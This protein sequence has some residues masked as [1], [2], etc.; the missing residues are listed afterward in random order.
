MRVQ[1]VKFPPLPPDAHVISPSRADAQQNAA[2][3]TDSRTLTPTR[4]ALRF[5]P[6]YFFCFVQGTPP[7][8][9]NLFLCAPEFGQIFRPQDAHVSRGV[10]PEHGMWMTLECRAEDVG[11]MTPPFSAA[12]TPQGFGNELALQLDKPPTEIAILCNNGI[13]VIRRR[14]LVDIFATAVQYSVRDEGLESEVKRFIRYYGREETTATALSVACAQGLDIPPD[15]RAAAIAGP[16]IVECARRVFIE[17]GGKPVLDENFAVDNAGPTVDDVRLSPRHQAI[18]LYIARLVRSIWQASVILEGVSPSGGLSVTPAVGLQKLRDIQRDMSA[19]K[20]FL[21]ANK[22][23]IEGLA[24]PD[25]LTRVT[26]KQD[27]LCLEAEHRALHS[28][29]VLIANIIEG[30]AFV[31]VLFDEGVEE[32]ILSLSEQHRRRIRTLKYEGLF[33][34]D[35]G[36]E[37]AK[38]LVKAIVNRSIASGSNVDTVA[39]A[40]RRRCGSFCSADDVVIFKAQEL[41]RKASDTGGTTEPGRR[42]LNESLR[43]FEQV[44]A[45]LSSEQLEWAVWQFVAMEFYAGKC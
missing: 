9:D 31:L 1:H 8:T 38:E 21:E 18:A 41:L 33:S 2:V 25:P 34:T 20:E 28:L 13:F 36:K 42:L 22:S 11:V 43:L 35:E 19:L 32:I 45:N 6:G 39:D 12:S 7:T 27:E 26:T 14:R 17:W 40:L 24:G 30:I 5:P 15:A 23:F 44:T 3:R 10:F 4:L 16:E 37:L 29:V